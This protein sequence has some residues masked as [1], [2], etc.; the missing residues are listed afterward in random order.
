MEITEL[1]TR[2]ILSFIVLFILARIMGR[3]EISQMTFFN[4]VSAIAI[5]SI[6][7]TLVTNENFGITNGIIAL[8]AW[9]V[10]TIAMG[11]I[12]IKFKKARKVTTGE[13]II[14][15]KNG[16]VMENSLRKT[17]LDMDSLTSLLRKNKVFSLTDVDYAIFETSGNLSVKLKENKLP[18]TREDMNI[19]NSTAKIYPTATEVISDGIINTNNLKRLNLDENWIEQQLQ[20]AGINSLSEVFYAE[21]Q[22]DGSLY[23]DNKDDFVQ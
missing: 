9:A 10:F 23:I 22:P 11:I 17:R 7:A 13:P 8:S 15:I 21:V 1:L 14:V 2:A 16:K 19:L 4:F 20:L 5:G 18:L 12:D 3:K 6:A